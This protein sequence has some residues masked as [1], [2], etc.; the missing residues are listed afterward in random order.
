MLLI[1]SLVKRT[2]GTATWLDPPY[3]IYYASKQ[4]IRMRHVGCDDFSFSFFF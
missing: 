1:S 2:N 4:I 3:L